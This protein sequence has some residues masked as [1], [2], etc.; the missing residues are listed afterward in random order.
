M[1]DGNRHLGYKEA[2]NAIEVQSPGSK[3]AFYFGFLD[4][5]APAAR[6]GGRAREGRAGALRAL[7]RAVSGRDLQLLPFGRAGRKGPVV[8]GA[9]SAGERVLL[10]D[11]R[12]RRY[13]VILKVGSEF[14]SHGGYIPHDEL[15]GRVEGTTVRATKG[16]AYTV[17]EAD[18]RR[19]RAEDAPGSTGHLPEGHRPDLDA[20]RHLSGRPRARVGRRLGGPLPRPAACRRGHRRATSSARTSPTKAQQN[21]VA[22]AGEEVLARYRVE[23]RDCYEGIDEAGLDRIVLD[24]PGALA[25]RQACRAR[26]EPGRHPPRIHA[27]DRAGR[28]APGGAGGSTVH[29]DLDDRGV[30][31][32]LAHRGA[33]RATRPPDGRAHRLPHFDAAR[34][35]VAVG[36]R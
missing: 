24:L 8:R 17:V 14:H 1:A 36:P 33:V 4:K 9:L 11:P 22:F 6:R 34:R 7:R 35:L 5:V 25:G 27:D 18:P 3:H 20:R 21:V 26:V 23:I 28:A 10:I 32:Q 13:L 19:L 16:L 31:P 30:A 12:G 2:L 29:A 15:I